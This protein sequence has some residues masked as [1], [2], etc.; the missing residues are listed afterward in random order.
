MLTLKLN[1][2]VLCDITDQ[3]LAGLNVDARLSFGYQGVFQHSEIDVSTRHGNCR[4]PLAE[5]ETRIKASLSGDNASA[6]GAGRSFSYTSVF[7][8]PSSWH[9][10][11]RILGIKPRFW[12]IAT[13][14]AKAMTLMSKNLARV[15]A[16][17]VVGGT[18]C[19]IPPRMMLDGGK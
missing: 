10:E 6:L 8:H 5:P 7:H 18:N 1:S 16:M 11:D 14:G 13:N 2:L 9:Q 12:G 3:I 15:S 17:G 19:R 4:G